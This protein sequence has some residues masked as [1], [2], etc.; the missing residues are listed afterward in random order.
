MRRK[1]DAHKDEVEGVAQRL[2]SERPE[3]SP[4]ELDR[5]KTSAMSRAKAG[6]RRGRAGA[7]RL[8]TAGLTVG[9]LAAGTGGVIAGGDQGHGNAAN[10]QYGS[11][12]DV[13]NNVG[14][15]IDN[16]GG[17]E[18]NNGNNNGNCNH[19]SFNGN[20]TNS[21]NTTEI[22]NTTTITNSSVTVTATPAASSVLGSTTSKAKTGKIK[23]HVRIP[24]KSKVKKVTLKLNGKRYAVISGKKASS[25]FNL[26]NLPCGTEKLQITVTLTSGKVITQQ[27]TYKL[28]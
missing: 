21:N 27:H 20:T 2:R 16:E 7:R 12:C 8:A 14:N 13:G 11:N 3:A 25:T 9:L 23:I 6:T 5:I 17:N 1:N 19:N 22:N 15:N 18:N 24:R 4:L 10:T 28:C 26:T